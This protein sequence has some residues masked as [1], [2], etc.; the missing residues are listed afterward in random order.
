MQDYGWIH[1]PKYADH[2]GLTHNRRLREYGAVRMVLS[3][4]ELKEAIIE[5]IAKPDTASLVRSE[6]VHLELGDLD[7]KVSERLADACI[8]SYLN[9]QTGG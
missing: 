4:E 6:T 2:P 5:S 3:R 8:R 9:C 7:G 1:P